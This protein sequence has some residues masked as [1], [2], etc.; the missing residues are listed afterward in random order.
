[1]GE[2]ED[3]NEVGNHPVAADQPWWSRPGV[4]HEVVV[5]ATARGQTA[6]WCFGHLMRGRPRRPWRPRRLHRSLGGGGHP[7]AFEERA[8]RTLVLDLVM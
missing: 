2:D 5:A 4:R 6:V 3:R 7:A 1:M 8:A